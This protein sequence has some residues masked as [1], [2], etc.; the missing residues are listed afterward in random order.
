MTLEELAEGNDNH[1]NIIAKEAYLRLYFE[2]ASGRTL[3]ASKKT[4]AQYEKV[5][6]INVLAINW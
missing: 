1:Y 4:S 5:K 2:R 6:H 3:S